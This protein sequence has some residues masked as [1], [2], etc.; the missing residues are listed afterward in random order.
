MEHWIETLGPWAVFIGLMVEGEVAL[1][2]AGY[3][4]QHGYLPLLP[5]LL[6]GTLGGTCT[7]SLY[8]WLGRKYGVK[9][10][11]SRKSLRPLRARAILMLRRYGHVMAFSVRFAFGLRIAL[12]IAIGA[13]RM[14]PRAFHTYN[15][16]GSFVFAVFYLAMGYGVGRVIHGF[17]VRL[18]I[19]EVHAVVGVLVLG[20][21]I[22]LVR[23][24][25][26]YHST[27]PTAPPDDPVNR[28]R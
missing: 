25:R 18:G 8:Y 5:T 20:A 24:W 11:R 13:S 4:I 17:I 27:D 10:L 19:S 1:I 16:A 9:L 2:L 22:W 21:L 23:E 28:P 15:L 26:L 6:L 12:P 3:A 7:D 14:K